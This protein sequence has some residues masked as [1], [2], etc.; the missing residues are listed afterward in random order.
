LLLVDKTTALPVAAPVNT[1]PVPSS[2]RLGSWLMH[3]FSPPAHGEDYSIPQ[4]MVSVG[5]LILF[6]A[7]ACGIGGTLTAI[8]NMGQIGQSLGYLIGVWNYAGRVTDGYASEALLLV[9][10]PLLFAVVSVLFG[11][12]RRYSTLYNLSAAASPYTLNVHVAEAA[13]QHGGTLPAGGDDKTCMG[14]A[15][16]GRSF[17]IIAEATAAGALVSLVLVWRTRDFYRGD[18]YAKI[19]QFRGA[20]ESGGRGKEGGGGRVN[21]DQRNG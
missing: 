3:T 10:W 19:V 6:L 16:F 9:T 7:T 15:C 4:A 8:D 14:A 18:I 20:T 12:I 5:M 17:L 1:P 2:C 21:G 11:L 13:R